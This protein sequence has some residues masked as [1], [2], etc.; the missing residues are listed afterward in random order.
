MGLVILYESRTNI[1]LCV[2]QRRGT[3]ISVNPKQI[4]VKGKQKNDG[5]YAVQFIF[6]YG[7]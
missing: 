6:N 7:R 3:L 5:A 2:A 4:L 1:I